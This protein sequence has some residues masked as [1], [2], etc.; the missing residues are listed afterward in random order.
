M[1]RTRQRLCSLALAVSIAATAA[2]PTWARPVDQFLGSSAARPSRDA[3]PPAQQIRVVRVSPTS[4]F[5]W[6]DAE[7]GAG[8]ALALATIGVG[9]ALALGNRRRQGRTATTT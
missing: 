6:G 3:G 9:S 7:I 5:D 1:T 2:P 8:A 4:D